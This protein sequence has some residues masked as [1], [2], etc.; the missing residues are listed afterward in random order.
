MAQVHSALPITEALDDDRR[1]VS[2]FTTSTISSVEL[3]L[4]LI[5]SGSVVELVSGNILKKLCG[6][7]VGV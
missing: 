6:S 1:I 7:G 2:I 3:A 4:S 5:N